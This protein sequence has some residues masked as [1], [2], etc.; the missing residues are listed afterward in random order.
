MLSEH[1]YGKVEEDRAQV[2]EPVFDSGFASGG[3]L[4]SLNHPDYFRSDSG[5][6]ICEKFDKNLR[7]GDCGPKQQAK[8]V[9]QSQS[10]I[11]YCYQPDA[12]GDCQLHLAIA[13]GVMDVVNALIRMAPTP[14]HLDTQ[15][16]ELYTPLHIAVLVDQP[17][18]VRRLVVAGASTEIR[19]KE[20]NSPFHL[21]AKRGL[22][23]CASAL[24][25]P[26]SKDELKEAAVTPSINHTRLLAVLDQKNYNGE[27][28]VHLAT[29]GQHYDFIRY[30]NLQKADLNSMEGRSG[31]TALHYAVN[32]GDEF[33]V[34]LLADPQEHGGCGVDINK[35]DWSGRTA[36]QCAKIN[37]S[38]NI[39]HYLSSL[40]GC[41]V[42]M[43]DSDED[44]EFDQD[45]DIEY[46]RDDRDFNDIEIRTVEST[47]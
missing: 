34:T 18:M 23:R 21:A 7:I 5:I 24:L 46:D 45:E 43:D 14:E 10:I 9:P 37:G 3:T 17:V 30:L 26:I 6:G 47:A 12:E 35:R 31:K 44:F 32:M 15:N 2:R 33:M 27:H 19:D 42:S 8:V 38:K 25:R 28:C 41:D 40:P 16:N 11:Q 20:G 29:F 22:E 4:S 1:D 39:F 36:L 13:E